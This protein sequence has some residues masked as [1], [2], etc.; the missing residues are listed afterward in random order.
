M[1]IAIFPGTFD[2]LT[3]GHYDLIKRAA[4]LFDK[5]I[6]L[7]GKNTGKS[8]LFSVNERIEMIEDC[9]SVFGNVEV[10]SYDGLTVDFAGKKGAIV[11]VRGVRAFS[12]F[13]Y[14]LQM[15]LMNRR[16]N[17]EVETMFLMPKNEYSFINSSLIKSVAK[18]GG[19]IKEFVPD[20]IGIKLLGKMDKKKT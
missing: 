14:E 20:S 13:E 1:K 17:S 12:D 11:L 4:K 9:V 10:A 6:V 19:D 7:I 8:P 16:L 5:L 18:A 15:A 3:L 2:P